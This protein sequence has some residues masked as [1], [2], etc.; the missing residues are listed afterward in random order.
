MR[1]E[2][3]TT[4]GAISGRATPHRI[5]DTQAAIT[6][7]DAIAAT[8]R[9]EGL[10]RG[11]RQNIIAALRRTASWH[12]AQGVHAVIDVAVLSR[13]LDKITAAKLGF[14][15]QA[16]LAAFRSNLRR[17]LRLAGLRVMPGSHRTPPEGEWGALTDRLKSIDPFLHAALSRFV[18]IAS[19]QGWQASEVGPGHF[20]RFSV[21]L[22]TECVKSKVK[23][24]LRKTRSAWDRARTLVPGWPQQVLAEPRSNPRF[25]ARPWSD[26]PPTLEVDA[27]RFVGRDDDFL[28][29]D[30]L[31]PIRERTRVNYLDAL[32][33]T[34]TL[35]VLAGA[36]EPGELHDL[37]DLIRIDR[38][39][40]AIGAMAK[41]TGN[42]CGN[43][44]HLLACLLRAIAMKHCGLPKDGAQVRELDRYYR[45]TRPPERRMSAKTLNRFEQFNQPGLLDRLLQLPDHL[46]QLAHSRKQ[47]DIRSAKLVRVALFLR[48]LLDLGCRQGNVVALDLTSQCLD[49]GRRGSNIGIDIPGELVKNGTP[50]RGQ[51]GRSTSAIFRLYRDTYRSVHGAVSSPYLFPRQDGTAWTTTAAWG[52]LTDIC[53]RYLGLD[54]NPHLVRALVGKII[55]DQDSTGYPL[56]QELLGHKS[57]QTTISFYAPLDQ[58]RARAAYHRFLGERV[59]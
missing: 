40:A 57:L 12:G 16:S 38:A 8:E 5:G 56:V 28:S 14:V 6:Y 35:A 53:A 9:S 46:V 39:K 43:S 51:L 47:V 36:A 31:L 32:R 55:L 54:V 13:K 19:Q 10:T 49:D 34:A 50:I 11:V 15:S 3:Q 29:D 25:Y 42:Q 41:R 27:R 18:H 17:G 48:I 37:S 2:H 44:T 30:L 24:T 26:F 21:L 45:K 4:G 23:S 22:E 58:Q 20:E 33:R 7:S 59:T 52:D 1:G